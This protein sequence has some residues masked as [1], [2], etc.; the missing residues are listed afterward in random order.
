MQLQFLQSVINYNDEYHYFEQLDGLLQQVIKISLPPPLHPYAYAQQP[1]H[2]NLQT[3]P[4]S[5]PQRSAQKVHNYL[6][7]TYSTCSSFTGSICGMS[8]MHCLKV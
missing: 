1:P 7:L 2:T 5:S 4:Q 8:T 6:S 3:P